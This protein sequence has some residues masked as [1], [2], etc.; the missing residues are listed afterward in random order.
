M[1][2]SKNKAFTLI[3]LLVVIAIIGLLSSV[4]LVSMRGA[5][6]KARI[7]KGFD[8]SSRIHN[9]LGV[10]AVGVWSFD[11]GSG[12]TANDSSGLGSNGALSGS[13]AWRC[14]STDISYTPSGQGCSLEFN[15][16]S[17]FVNLG[18]PAVLNKSITNVTIVAWAKLGRALGANST[19]YEIFSNEI[20]QSYGY[21]FRVEDA[22]NP[23]ISGRI[24]F[25]T[26]QA[27][28]STGITANDK[29]YPN[30]LLWHHVVAVKDGTIGKIYVDGKEVSGYIGYSSLYNP[31]DSVGNSQ[32]AGLSGQK[33]NG[34]LD[35]V[36]IY[37]AALTT[38]QI[39]SQYYA[40]LDKLLADG[41]MDKEEYEWRLAR[42]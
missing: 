18:Q 13:P 37:R 3:E 23:A 21:L 16:S 39:Q 20:Y 22:A 4:V 2:Y 28:A 8:F 34:L 41:L 33:F 31:V 15:G 26:S 19:N 30:D 17:N 27:G 32:I 12:S 29:S 42:N 14:A 10:D 24:H 40:G 11:E 9:A 35:E 1:F 25:R 7:A 38:F 6:E 5:G 36:R